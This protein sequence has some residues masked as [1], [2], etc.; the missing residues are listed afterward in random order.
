M[1]TK[2]VFDLKT[3]TRLGLYGVT[4]ADIQKI[5]NKELGTNYKIRRYGRGIVIQCLRCRK[6]WSALP[7]EIVDNEIKRVLN[8]KRC[9]CEK[10]N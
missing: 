5:I 8:L 7:I 9:N 6:T 1:S 4:Y 10:K 2:Y 3:V